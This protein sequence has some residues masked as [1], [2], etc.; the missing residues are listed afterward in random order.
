MNIKPIRTDFDHASALKEIDS[1]WSAKPGSD[2]FDRLEMLV[3][4][5][6]RYEDGR[7]PIAEPK[8]W[9]PVDVLQYAIDELGHTQTELGQVLKSRSRASEILKRERHL[10]LDM[11][12][13]IY[14]QWKIPVALLIK[15][16]RVRQMA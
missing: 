4:L 13:A 6:E 7:W 2:E 3:L 12:R 5:V 9:D 16:Y 14:A 1:L 10:T 11:I 15:P 8:R